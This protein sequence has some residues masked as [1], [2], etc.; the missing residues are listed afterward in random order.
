M[1]MD[2]KKLIVLIFLFCSIGLY[3]QL[4][5]ITLEAAS[6]DPTLVVRGNELPIESINHN[7]N[8]VFIQTENKK[9]EIQ[10]TGVLIDKN[11]AVKTIFN[12]GIRF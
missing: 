5:K 6:A 4:D 12:Q 8:A 3:A 10:I 11:N 7:G 2:N 1:A 9:L